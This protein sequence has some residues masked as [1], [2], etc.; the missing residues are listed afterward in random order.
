LAEIKF[1][2]GRRRLINTPLVL[3]TPAT[4]CRCHPWGSIQLK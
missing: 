4:I 1:G 3:R 2:A